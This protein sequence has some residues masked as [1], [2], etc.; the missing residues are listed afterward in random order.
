MKSKK[1][2]ER[3]NKV[4]AYL[5]ELYNAA[6][7][8]NITTNSSSYSDLLNDIFN[9]KTESYREIILVALIGRKLD[10]N[11]S[12]YSG[13]YDCK[14]RAIFEGPIKDFCLTKGFP[15]TKS[16]PLNIAKASNINEDWSSQRDP[17]EDAIK[18][19]K[20]I[21]QIDEGSDE[22]RRNIGIDLLRKYINASI[23]VQELSVQIDPNSDPNFLA[24]LCFEMIEKAPDSGNTPQR[25]CGYM[26]STYHTITNTGIIVT[27]TEDSASTTSTTSKKPGDINEE[28][29]DG[30]ILKVYEI[31]I[32]PFNL[33]R[34]KDSFDCICKYNEE[35]NASLNEVIVICQ[36]RDCPTEM[37]K[38]DLQFCLG[39]YEYQNVIYYF[40]DIYEWILYMLQHMI[41]SARESFYETFNDYVNALNTHEYV[42]KEWQLLNSKK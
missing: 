23:H 41:P 6:A 22:L 18:V 24:H 26:L 15:H 29:P 16:G 32:K 5:N 7:D 12:A 37:T 2:I 14:P 25:I 30:T 1:T 3:D 9:S 39:S 40:W 33:S 13:F 19:V 21:K 36:K 34:I 38:S 17:Q 10:D 28:L 27:G 8:K 31:T 11:F 4:T 42:K 20:L 35:C